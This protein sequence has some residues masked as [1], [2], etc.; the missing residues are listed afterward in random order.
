MGTRFYEHVEMAVKE[1]ERGR[2]E[3]KREDLATNIKVPP[4][5]LHA[6]A[7]E[8]QW[9]IRKTTTTTK[10]NGND[11]PHIIIQGSDLHDD[12]DV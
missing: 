5:T 2:E 3:R 8:T 10:E 1:R 4:F 6:Y 12:S 9:K 7:M 11:V